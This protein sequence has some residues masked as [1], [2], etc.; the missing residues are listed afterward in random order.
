MAMGG[1]KSKILIFGATG[2]LGKY[3]VKASVVL[4]H[5]TYAYTRPL[6]HNNSSSKL[7]LL[8]DFESMGVTIFYGELD[9]HEKLV[10]VLQQVEVVISTLAVP[11]HLDQLKIISAMKDAG[12]IKRFVPSEYGNEADR[13]TSALPPFE[14]LLANKRK[15][16]RAAEA[17][18]L[19]YTYVAANSFLVYFIDY[20]LHPHEKPNELVVYGTGQAKVVFNYEE[21]IAA[22]TVKAATDPRVANRV[23]IYR[24]PANVTT[25]LELISAW[26]EKTGRTFKR[27]HVPEEE[28]IKLS[29]TLPFPDNIPVAV[30]HNIF[31]KGDQMT[32]ELM[33]EDLEASKLYPDYSYT[34]IDKYL[35]MCVVNP[36]RPKLAAFA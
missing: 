10:S 19:P 32:Y 25:Q 16:R 36:P 28:I 22:F 12:T 5:P 11:Q 2:Y 15:I 24:P 8:K 23:I 13:I 35:D 7:D 20:L 21:D 17:A 34:T 18:G 26:E 14:A 29:E 3:M 30:L 27:V 9:E 4:G 1:E 31:I 6:S 33:E